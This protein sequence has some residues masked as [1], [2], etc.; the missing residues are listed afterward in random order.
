LK[1]RITGKYSFFSAVW[2]LTLAM[3]VCGKTEANVKSTALVSS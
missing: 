2:D 3:A 1:S